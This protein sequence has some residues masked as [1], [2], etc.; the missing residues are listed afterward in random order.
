MCCWTRSVATWTTTSALPSWRPIWPVWPHTEEQI[1]VTLWPQAVDRFGVHQTQRHSSGPLFPQAT[2]IYPAAFI[3]STHTTLFIRPVIDQGQHPEFRISTSLPHQLQQLRPLCSPAACPATHMVFQGRRKA[4]HHSSKAET[5]AQRS[6]I[7]YKRMSR[8]YW[9]RKTQ[10]SGL[11]QETA[12]TG[13]QQHWGWFG[14]L[15]KMLPDLQ[16]VNKFNMSYETICD[17]GETVLHTQD[18]TTLKS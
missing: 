15:G 1:S 14:K 6:S 4:V 12:S 2:A 3:N 16:H 17:G 18:L 5:A 10:F 9:A 8:Q 7:K 13:Q 11:Q